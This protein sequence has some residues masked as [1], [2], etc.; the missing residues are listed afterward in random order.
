MFIT[1]VYTPAG[2]NGLGESTMDVGS[3]IRISR[4]PARP[5]AVFNLRRAGLLVVHCPSRAMQ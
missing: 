2:A 3:R 1:T 4:Q 5:R